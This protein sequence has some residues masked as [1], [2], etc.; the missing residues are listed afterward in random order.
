MFDFSARRKPQASLIARHHTACRSYR[1]ARRGSIMGTV[2][3][4]VH[5]GDQMPDPITHPPFRRDP[6]GNRLEWWT[7]TAEQ[8]GHALWLR[9]PIEGARQVQAV[10]PLYQGLRCLTDPSGWTHSLSSPEPGAKPEVQSLLSVLKE[11]VMVP[12]EVIDFVLA[13]DWYKVPVEDVD[14]RQW[15]NTGTGEL[16]SSGKYRYRHAPEP[17]AV[18]GR[19]LAGRICDVVS[20]H[21]LL[22][23]ASMILDV[24]GHDGRRVSFG[25]RLAATV[26]RDLDMPMVKVRGKSLFRSQAKE[27]ERNRLTQLLDDEFVVP[28]EV[29]GHCVLIVD[30]VIRSGTSMAAVCNA[31]R[32]SGAGRV[33][34][35]SA[36][37]TLRR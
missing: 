26:A 11:V 33:L 23:S 2:H 35:V 28:G 21:A 3:K 34:G 6:R 14:P 31:A 27:L 19:S 7:T 18:A 12:S 32:R 1:P 22:S 9:G 13:L 25:S 10:D 20:R 24:P 36:V 16:V 15:P 4:Y 29:M 8:D 37:R 17:Q 5:V 30:D